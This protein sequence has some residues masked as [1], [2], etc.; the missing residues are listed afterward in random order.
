MNHVDVYKLDSRTEAF[1][2]NEKNETKANN[3][4]NRQEK[5][6]FGSNQFSI[7][8]PFARKN[9]QFLTI[10]DLEVRTMLDKS[11]FYRYSHYAC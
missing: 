4:N 5:I 7:F 11:K 9:Q 2:G 1:V 6:Q 10:G 3:L 8:L